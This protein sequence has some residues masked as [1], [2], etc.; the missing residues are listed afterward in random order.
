MPGALTFSCA[1]RRPGKG[2]RVNDPVSV[3]PARPTVIAVFN[4]GGDD[5]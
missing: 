2:G 1:V 4:G 3:S 5:K